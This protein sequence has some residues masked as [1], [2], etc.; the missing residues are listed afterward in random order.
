M[1]T[2]TQIILLVLLS[3]FTLSIAQIFFKLGSE[4]FSF[5]IQQ[6]FNFHLWGGGLG[7]FL[8]GIFL[9]FALK[10]GDLSFVYPITA[11]SYVFVALLSLYI[12]KET[13]YLKQWLGLGVIVMG[14]LFIGSEEN[15]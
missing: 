7:L 15:E 9:L 10:K 2:K 6:I 5:S 13:I 14:V 1:K 4:S 3:T 8:G 12:L 11:V